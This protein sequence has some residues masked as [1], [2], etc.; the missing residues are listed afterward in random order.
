MIPNIKGGAWTRHTSTLWELNNPGGYPT[1]PVFVSR[2][3]RG[4]L[5]TIDDYSVVELENHARY[6]QLSGNFDGNSFL[7][8]WSTK[9]MCSKISLEGDDDHV[10]DSRSL[11]F[12]CG[13]DQHHQTATGYSSA[14]LR[15]LRVP[16]VWRWH[17]V[18]WTVEC[19]TADG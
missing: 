16:M 12:S 19:W 14:V 17:G 18:A 3:S 2:P 6:T 9:R 5:Y 10:S 15:G 8:A 11:A 7:L 13:P 1:A 4:Q